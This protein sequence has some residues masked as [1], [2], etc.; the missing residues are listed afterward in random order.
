MKCGVVYKHKPN[1]KINGTLFYCFEYFQ[2]LKNFVDAKFYIVGI[3]DQDLNL[4]RKMFSEKYTC[5]FDG[6]LPIKI[7]E[8][9]GLKLD[10]TLVFDVMTFD[11]CKAFLTGQVHCY[12]NNTHPNYKY[13][14][15]REVIY[16]GTYSEYQVFDIHSHIKINFD[17]FKPLQQQGCGVFIS[18]PNRAYIES[19]LQRYQQQFN[20]PVYLKKHDAGSG[21]IFDMIDSVHYV[22]TQRDTNNR[23]I[24]EAFYYDKQVTLEYV[25]DET[26][27]VYYRY[28]DIIANGLNNYILT[29]DDLM[30]QACLK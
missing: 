5:S 1:N 28:N 27:S 19:N 2:F 18:C 25:Y 8:L 15:S 24:P 23:I 11:H 12:S 26:D 13:Q 17:I 7:T 3:N 16:Y 29:E 20:K 9:H 14:D 6:V 21:N 4:I 22:H 10:R 30:V